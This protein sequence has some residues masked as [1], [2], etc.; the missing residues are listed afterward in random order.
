MATSTRVGIGYDIHALEAGRRLVLAGVEI[1]HTHGPR[2][3]SDGDVVLHA[4]ADAL[5]G[6]AGLGD[7][8]EHF[9]D[10]DPAWAGA[11][12]DRFLARVVEMV[13]AGGWAVA[14]ADTNVLLEKPRLGA[15]KAAMRRR[16]ADLLGVAPTAVGLKARTHE[17]LGPIGEGKA[18]A[19]QAVV[20]IEKGKE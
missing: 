11:S 14:S 17:G 5:L 12:S 18:V 19:A 9:P 8:G 16:L 1:P 7:L 10:S 15:H 2:A 6:A 3:H 4:V 13:R 20:V